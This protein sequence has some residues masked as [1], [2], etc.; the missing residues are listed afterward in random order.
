MYNQYGARIDCIP[1]KGAGT[2]CVPSKGD[3]DRLCAIKGGLRQTVY[4]QWGPG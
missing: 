1:S 4:R 3:W 2:D